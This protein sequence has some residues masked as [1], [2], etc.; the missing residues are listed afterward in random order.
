M[1]KKARHQRIPK[2][3]RALRQKTLAIQWIDI[4]PNVNIFCSQR[5]KSYREVDL[6]QFPDRKIRVKGPKV[7]G[8]DDAECSI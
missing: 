3:A 5:R 6:P 8:Q 4:Y 7:D 1:S 2:S